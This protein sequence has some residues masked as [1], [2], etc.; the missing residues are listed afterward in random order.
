MKRRLLTSLLAAAVITAIAAPGPDWN[1]LYRADNAVSDAFY[2]ESGLQNPDIVVIGID[3]ETLDDLGSVYGLRGAMAQAIDNLNA[4]PDNRPAVIGIDM[5]YTGENLDSPQADQRLAEA[6]GRYGNVVVAAD[7]AFGPAMARAGDGSFYIQNTVTGWYPPYEALAQAAQY[8]AVN[9]SYDADGIFRHARLYIDCPDAGRL[10]SFS[11][12]IYLM[13]CEA[14]DLTPN[15]PPETS[16]DGYYYLPFSG[17]TSAYNDGLNF[18]NLYNGLTDQGESIPLKRFKNRI[19]LIGPTASGFQDEYTTSLKHDEK[20]PGVVINANMIEAF[21][22]GFFPGEAKEG[23]Q[24][25]LLFAISFLLTFFMWDRRVLSL[26][27][28][29]LAACL[30]WLGLCYL[31]YHKGETILHVL[32]VPF[33]ASVVFIGSV[34]LNYIRS[35]K[36][37][38]RVTD[39]FGHYIDPVIRDRLLEQGSAALDRGGTTR[40]IAVLFV[41][42]RGFTALSESLDARTVVDIVNRYLTLTTDCIMR[43]HGTLDKFIGDC[44]M[45]IWNAPLLQEDPVGLACRAAL[46]MLDASKAL[47]EEL[48]ETYGRAVSFGI[49]INWGEA[50]VG[51]IGAPKRLDYTAIGDTVNT[52]ERLEANA[53]GGTILISRAV[54]DCLGERADVTPLG[55]DFK[56]KGKAE[57]IEILRL[58][59]LKD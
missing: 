48:I 22:K 35:Q 38:R 56:L 19:V 31:C 1:L 51:S 25:L 28:I 53:P 55:S 27:G 54:A 36:E 17:E 32:W 47:N 40:D 23:L 12:L 39:T 18:L 7:A 13:W 2:Q 15:E 5:L 46:D 44:T 33:A 11:R 34:A 30:I 43:N 26:A 50:V 42:V 8:G 41:D 59:A 24:L 20:M 16:K 14:N 49:G 21:Q 10:D 45:A 37:K 29:W 6:A 52:A 9:G 4:D 57:G 58:D 3:Q